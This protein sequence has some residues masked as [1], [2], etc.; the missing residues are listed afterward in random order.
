LGRKVKQHVRRFQCYFENFSEGI[1]FVL[2]MMDLTRLFSAERYEIYRQNN[3]FEDLR[4]VSGRMAMLQ[5]IYKNIQEGILFFAGV[6]ILIAGGWA[7]IVGRMTTGELISFYFVIELMRRQLQLVTSSIPQIME[8]TESLNSLYNLL[9]VQNSIPY[10]GIR[11]VTLQGDII[12]KDVNFQYNQEPTLININ[13][14]IP[15]KGIVAIT[16]PNG[17]G[18]SSIFNLILG[19]YAPQQGELFAGM[20]S[21]SQ[22]EMVHLR[23]SFGVVPQEPL[24]FQ[25]SIR[26]NICYGIENVSDDAIK[27]ACQMAIAHEFISKLPEGYSSPLG[28]RGVTLSGGERQR[29]CFARAFL[30]DPALLLLDEPTNHLDTDVIIKLMQNIKNWSQNRAV[31]II[32]HNKKVIRQA[33]I[34]YRLDNGCITYAGPPEAFFQMQTNPIS[35]EHVVN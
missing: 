32:S 26:E 35:K 1:L 12:L 34:V 29:L 7:V 31:L 6:L 27:K 25:G 15:S 3:K 28:E 16:G 10:T 13:L 24:L 2:Q 23:R 5:A 14:R 18:K 9:H 17:A 30:R 4:V 19:L 22:I 33:E 11:P 21:Y 8:G 20:Y